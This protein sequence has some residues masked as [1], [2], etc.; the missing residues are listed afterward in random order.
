M[1]FLQ[2]RIYLLVLGITAWSYNVKITYL[3]D[4]KVWKACSKLKKCEG[5]V[6]NKIKNFGFSY[7]EE[8]TTLSINFTAS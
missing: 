5:W 1:G 2:R 8:V 4:W 3:A 7:F 6:N